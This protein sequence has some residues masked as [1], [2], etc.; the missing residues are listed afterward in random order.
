MTILN[1][2]KQVQSDRKDEL[3]KIQRQIDKLEAEEYQAQ[4][5]PY[6]ELAELAHTILC[7]YQHDDQC[8]WGYEEQ[9][10]PDKT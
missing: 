1:D 7:N 4:G 6:R 2:L 3:D 9:T 10:D 5:K 8:G